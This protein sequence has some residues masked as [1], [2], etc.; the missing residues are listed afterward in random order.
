MGTYSVASIK[1]K[2]GSTS[3]FQAVMTA[4]E[5]ASTVRTAMDFAEFDNFMEH[6]KMQ[7]KTN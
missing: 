7:R 2:M 1:A 4:A 5:L 3:Y 6:E